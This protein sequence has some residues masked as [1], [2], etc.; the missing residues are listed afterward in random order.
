M[1]GI[2][3]LSNE[4][5]GDNNMNKYRAQVLAAQ[6]RAKKI[7]NK[8]QDLGWTIKQSIID[9][10]NMDI[11]KNIS[12]KKARALID[13]LSISTIRTTREINHRLV[14]EETTPIMSGERKSGAK[15]FDVIHMDAPK[16][17]MKDVSFNERTA[18]DKALK[19]IRFVLNESPNRDVAQDIEN[20]LYAIE[21]HSGRKIF[22]TN[23]Q[24]ARRAAI[25]SFM[26]NDNEI[27]KAVRE[28]EESGYPATLALTSLYQGLAEEFG[29]NERGLAARQM[30]QF[31][32]VLESVGRDYST[33]PEERKVAADVLRWLIE[34]DNLWQS[35]RKRFKLKKIYKQIYDS[36]SLL[37]DVSD[38][39]V[40]HPEYR[41]KILEKLVDLM[42]RNVDPSEIL[43]QLED[44]V[45]E[46]NDAQES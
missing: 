3:Y 46:L 15:V 16:T 18:V 20:K 11:P 2:L 13:N 32:Q 44:Y 21:L 34:N 9:R 12:A 26:V 6:T 45:E 41:I 19:Q 39:M 8:Y 5:T 4:R 28:A 31:Q 17:I 35:Y 40:D 24:T 37:V 30:R 23:D 43:Q 42:K 1:C 33:D 29:T 38:V 25:L 27:K 36:N 22:T 14:V 10:A 7:I